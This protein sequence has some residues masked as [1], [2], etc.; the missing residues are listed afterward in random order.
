MAV[1][2]ALFLLVC[3]ACLLAPVAPSKGNLLGGWF[4]GISE[5]ASTARWGVEDVFDT[6]KEKAEDLR[7]AL[8]GDACP[9]AKDPLRRLAEAFDHSIRAQDQAVE[10]VLA[11]F[12]ARDV[13]LGQM[14]GGAAGAVGDGDRVQKPLV[15][16]FTG[17][18]GVGK[19]ETGNTIAEAYFTKREAIG[20]GT[21]KRPKGLIVFRGEVRGCGVGTVRRARPRACR[22]TAGVM[23]GC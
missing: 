8:Q 2:P 18:T 4:S 16:A 20:K 6:L 11:A 3:A 15:M 22:G 1:H 14:G 19:T 17:P 5:L 10:G 21:V 23:R 7:Y 9:V 12:E 13:N